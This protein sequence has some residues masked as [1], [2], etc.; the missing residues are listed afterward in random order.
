M[1]VRVCECAGSDIGMRMLYGRDSNEAAHCNC[2]NVGSR[3]VGHRRLAGIIVYAYTLYIRYIR[4]MLH[5]VY[6]AHAHRVYAIKHTSPLHSY[7]LLIIKLE[8]MPRQG[9]Y[10]L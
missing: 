10:L 7:C 5:R 3:Q 6:K 9:V 4:H 2:K 8:S 1:P